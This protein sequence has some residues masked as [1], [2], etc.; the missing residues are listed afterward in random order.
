[1]GA[2]PWEERP[3]CHPRRS[4]RTPPGPR[5]SIS[6]ALAYSAAGTC[7][8]H[9]VMVI[10]VAVR[11]GGAS[12][13]SAQEALAAEAPSLPAP[14]SATR[15]L[16]FSGADLESPLRCPARGRSGTGTGDEE[17]LPPVRRAH[18]PAR[19]PAPPAQ[20]LCG[21]QAGTTRCGTPPRWSPSRACE[22]AHSGQAALRPN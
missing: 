8:R 20:D 19:V 15:E 1:M 10:S 17:T 4:G 5:R 11:I 21:W 7:C 12:T 14:T 3:G 22:P 6:A 13:R 18:T 9:G 16:R 2:A